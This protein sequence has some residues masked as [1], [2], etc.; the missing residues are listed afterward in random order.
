[1]TDRGGKV[2]SIMVGSYCSTGSPL[3]GSVSW[4]R[5]GSGPP[6]PGELYLSWI[7]PSTALVSRRSRVVSA[8][9]ESNPDSGCHHRP[10]L[11]LGLLRPDGLLILQCFI[12]L[13]LGEVA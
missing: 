11:P 3:R 8:W 10:V 9:E 2:D 13:F 7:E 12:S 1:M 4:V 6:H 5:S